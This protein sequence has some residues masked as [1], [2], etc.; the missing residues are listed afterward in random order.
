MR[1]Y[2]SRCRSRSS[3]SSRL[4]EHRQRSVRLRAAIPPAGR[5][6][7]SST[8]FSSG[9]RK[10]SA[11]LTPWSLA[12]SSAMP[13]CI[14]RCS[15]SA[16]AGAGG[17]E[18]RGVKQPGG[19][20]RRRMAAFAFPGV[21]ADVVVIAAGRNERRARAHALHHLEA[22]HAA[23]EAER[24]IEIGDLEMNMPDPGAGDDGWVVGHVMS[25]CCSYL[26]PL[27]GRGR[28]REA[29][30][31]RGYRSIVGHNSRREPLT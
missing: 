1:D 6:R 13:A 23:I 18:D 14:T 31:V 7:Y 17:I 11:S 20:R 8:P 30:R 19:A 27:A 25:P 5:S 2:A 26:A 12:P 29:I 3:R 10:Y 9:S 4:R 15:A 28:I 21:E 22:E 24:A 16:S